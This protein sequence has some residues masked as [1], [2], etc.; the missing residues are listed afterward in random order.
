MSTSRHEEDSFAP[1]QIFKAKSERTGESFFLFD[2]EFCFEFFE[3]HSPPNLFRDAATL[4]RKRGTFANPPIFF[5]A[6]G[7]MVFFGIFFDP[8]LLFFSFVLAPL[9]IAMPV[10]HVKFPFADF[11]VKLR[12]SPIDECKRPKTPVRTYLFHSFN[13]STPV[14]FFY[15]RMCDIL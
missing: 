4:H 7:E 10:G 9:Y 14:N 15:L 6:V 12:K 5:V 1:E 13:N 3:R 2:F 11:I 8:R